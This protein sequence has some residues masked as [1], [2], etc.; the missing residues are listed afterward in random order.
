MPLL[1]NPFQFW[2]KL[3]LALAAASCFISLYTIGLVSQ[4]HTA[5]LPY[6]IYQEP[7][8]GLKAADFQFHLQ[9]VR[10]FWQ[11]PDGRLYT[12]EFHRKMM[13]DWTGFDVGDSLSFAYSP[14]RLLTLAPAG[15]L[16]DPAAY[17]AW[18]GAALL[19]AHAFLV[20]WILRC[21][22]PSEL[23]PCF[24]L[25]TVLLSFAY[26]GALALG[27]TAAWSSL[28]F[29]LLLRTEHGGPAKAS[30]PVQAALL[31]ILTAKPP[32]AVV[33]G[34]ALA[35]AGK[36]KPV[37]AAVLLVAAQAALFSL[38]LGASWIPDYLRLL[39]AFDRESSDPLFLSSLV[40]ERMSNLRQVLHL[41]LGTGD[42][43]ATSASTW[44]WLGSS[45]GV[46][47]WAWRRRLHPSLPCALGLA[48][49]CYSLF[50]PHLSF[51]E[52]LALFFPVCL[53]FQKAAGPA[54]PLAWALLL[55]I[56][57]SSGLLAVPGIM[58][59]A[60]LAKAGLAALFLKAC[61]SRQNFCQ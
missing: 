58:T 37:A 29:A 21:R 33:G 57:M 8:Q 55:L 61:L 26:Q 49:C 35:S 5:G 51:T 48:L 53:L 10:A 22:A 9:F 19:L 32:L 24:L 20:F 18:S 6:G 11:A 1:S 38:A 27:Q 50:S 23:L 4:R 25:E 39:G 44:L 34:V 52:D 30:W 59:L 45:A 54:V 41:A 42:A 60:F 2:R 12:P 47:A 40:V 13:R 31:W 17:L 3:A 36:I 15:L 14:T 56:L 28:L 7:G 46:L 16:P 43:L